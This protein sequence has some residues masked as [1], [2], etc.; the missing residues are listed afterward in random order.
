MTAASLWHLTPEHAAEWRAIRLA[1]LA[2]TPEAFDW[3]ADDPAHRCL[4]DCAARLAQ[5]EIWAAGDR[6]DHA[7]AVAGWEP[8]WTPGTETMGWITGVYARPEARGRG[9]V[10][11]LLARIAD[12]AA[13][14]GMDRLGLRV[15]VA[16]AAA[17]HRYEAEGFRQSGASFL[18]DA[19]LTEIEM[20]CPL[21]AS[22]AR[23]ALSRSPYMLEP[24]PPSR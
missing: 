21:P 23:S 1:A 10:T 20:L 8:G 13:A 15:G 7:L 14:A 16:N 17:R 11:A 18:N 22:D 4:A 12:R 24:P 3:P 9:L 6:Q 19:G 2:D 5:A